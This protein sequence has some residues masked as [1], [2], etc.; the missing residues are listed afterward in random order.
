MNKQILTLIAFTLMAV[1]ISSCKKK[2][3]TP[4]N[5]N[6]TGAPAI[7]G[8]YYFQAKI[9][10]VWVTWQEDNINWGSGMG[11][12]TSGGGGTFD[13]E[14]Y[15][16][17]EDFPG[18]NSGGIGIVKTG[19][20]DPSDYPTRNSLF[21]VGAKTFGKYNATPKVPGATVTYVTNGVV[22]SSEKGADQTG[23]AFSITAFVDNTIDI[24]S[25]KIVSATFN[26]KLYDNLGNTKTLTNGRFKGRIID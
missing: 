22:W 3:T 9:D 16:Y 14:E 18:D 8:T 20:I 12:N 7:T 11:T 6:N 26:C 24:G 13:I 21:T 17:V 23:S 15:G 10:G 4:T 25:T 1:G 2:D 5:N 19:V